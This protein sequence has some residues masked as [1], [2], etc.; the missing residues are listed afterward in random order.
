MK[1][2]SLQFGALAPSMS[3][4]LPMLDAKVAKSFD[5]DNTAISRARVRGYI[6]DAEL[7]RI[8]R[9]LAAAIGDAIGAA[10]KDQP[11]D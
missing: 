2:Y 10:A 11:H 7:T 4:Q 1:H 8:H 5:D 9:R 6:S 3:D